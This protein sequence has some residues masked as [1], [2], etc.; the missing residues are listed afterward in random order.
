MKLL[1]KWQRDLVVY[2]DVYTTFIIEGDIHDKQTWIYEE[3]DYCQPVSLDMF[4]YMYLKEEGYD[5]IVFYNTVDGFYNAFDDK[6]LKMFC[7]LADINMDKKMEVGE[8]L[9]SIR[10][11]LKTTGQAVAVIITMA[12]TMALIPD[13]LSEDEA[14]YY[15]KLMLMSMSPTLGMSG[16]TGKPL[17]NLV[18]MFSDKI[19]D[20]PAWFYLNNPYVKTM[21]IS[22]PEK[23]IRKYIISS[24]IN[25]I[26]GTS[27]LNDRDR[28]ECIEQFAL[29]TDGMSLVELDGVITLCRQQNIDIRKVRDAVYLFRYGQTESYWDKIDINKIENVE[30]ILQERVKGQQAAIA[31]VADIIS[32]A[33][34]GLSS[35]QGNHAKPKGVLFFAGPTG[36]GKTELAKSI[37][38]FVFGDEAFLTRFDMSEYGQS[39]S[40]QKLLGAPPGY[41]GYSAGGQLT[42]AIKEKPFSVILFDEI[43]KA[44]PSILDKFL[45]ILEDG[46]LTD[47]AGE[48]VYFSETLIIF[49]SNLGINSQDNYGNLVENVNRSMPYNEMRKRVL[50]A[51]QDY[52]K[53]KINRPELLNRIGDNF[54][55]FNYIDEKTAMD[56]LS[57]KI[58]SLIKKLKQE[59]NIELGLSSNYTNYLFSIALGNL[60]NGGRGIGNVVETYLV[61]PLARVLTKAKVAKNV[62]LM[63]DMPPASP[64]DLPIYRMVKI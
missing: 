24:K 17:T 54:V 21:T 30:N 53:Y 34:L 40:D 28:E 13:S 26:P 51:I 36:T 60:D 41:V 49:T 15:S 27:E 25:I 55:V 7:G 29:L 23:E 8:A 18:F 52:F 37:A 48:T 38:E 9:E 12:N 19:N 1:E 32:R 58:T 47:S 42:N 46:R 59:K 22:K 2:R 57:A 31:K 61:N 45:Q 10:N 63:L 64:G 56:I 62:Q 4:M 5:V 16:R 3:D 44:H 20:I 33:S 11:G 43:E 50:S 39:H 6:M 14:G 35:L